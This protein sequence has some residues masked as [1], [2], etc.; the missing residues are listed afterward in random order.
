[1]MGVLIIPLFSLMLW[2]NSIDTAGSCPIVL[3]FHRIGLN[4]ETAHTLV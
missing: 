1:M 2:N 3:S 4:L